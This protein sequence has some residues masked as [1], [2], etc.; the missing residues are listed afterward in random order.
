MAL[1]G[2]LFSRD[3]KVGA[4]GA[5]LIITEGALEPRAAPSLWSLGISAPMIVD[6]GQVTKSEPQFVCLS[7]GNQRHGHL[8][9]GGMGELVFANISLGPDPLLQRSGEL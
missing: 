7:N 8:A 5:R 3:P 2:S 1:P 9:V 4:L 6:L